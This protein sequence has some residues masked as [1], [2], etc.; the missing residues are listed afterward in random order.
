MIHADRLKPIRY[1]LMIVASKGHSV[2]TKV[3]TLGRGTGGLYT[4]YASTIYRIP[5]AVA[6]SYG[7]YEEYKKYIPS[8]Y[9]EKYIYKP[10]KRVAGYLGQALHTKST[11]S[12]A[13]SSGFYK[14][15][16]PQRSKYRNDYR[17][18]SNGKR[19][20]RTD[21]RCCQLCAKKLYNKGNMAKSGFLRFSS[22]RRSSNNS[23]LLN[24]KSWKQSDSSSTW[25]RGF[26]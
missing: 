19:N 11:S 12:F 25:Y 20:R 13:S 2:G 14:E 18:D 22:N 24:E 5:E 9:E 17:R 15:R 6:R 1:I 23:M 10:H 16:N 8:S 7:K 26:K 21:Q 4:Q 3:Q